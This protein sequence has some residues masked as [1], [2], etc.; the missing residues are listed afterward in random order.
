MSILSYF[1]TPGISHDQKKYVFSRGIFLSESTIVTNTA[2]IHKG[3]L[4][5]RQGDEKKV[6]VKEMKREGFLP[7]SFI[8]EGHKL[9][10]TINHPN[11]VKVHEVDETANLIL[12]EYVE[13][14]PIDPTKYDIEKWTDT[15]ARLVEIVQISLDI[16]YG[17]VGLHNRGLIH[18]DIKPDNVLINLENRTKLNDFDL[19]LESG[20]TKSVDRAGT[21]IYISPELVSGRILDYKADVFSFG[22]LFSELLLPYHQFIQISGDD[23][24]G[25]LISKR[26]IFRPPNISDLIP[27]MPESLA[28]ICRSCLS[29]EKEARPSANELVHLLQNGLNEI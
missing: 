10:R 5:D 9:M 16:L 3:S 12:M 24:K 14:N 25:K 23:E 17:I 15:R 1:P 20:S 11:L 26:A 13:G 18:R 22:I 7:F 4:I 21:E 2:R 8:M 28:H 6:V 29:F 19:V 27:F